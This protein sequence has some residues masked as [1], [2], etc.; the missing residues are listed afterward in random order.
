[1]TTDIDELL[2]INELLLKNDSSMIN[3]WFKAASLEHKD[4]TTILGCSLDK[5]PYIKL[6]YVGD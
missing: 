4:W 2:I 3:T 6:R 5:K 1:M